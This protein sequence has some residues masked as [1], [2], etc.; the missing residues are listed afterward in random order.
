MNQEI[1][2]RTEEI[3]Q[4]E[5]QR[6]QEIERRMKE[7]QMIYDQKRHTVLER[8]RFLDMLHEHNAMSAKQQI[9]R[10]Y[11]P[12]FSSYRFDECENIK[13]SV[14]SQKWA[15]A[16]AN[17]KKAEK[18]NKEFRTLLEKEEEEALM[19]KFQNE[20]KLQKKLKKLRKSQE[21]LLSHM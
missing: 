16:R 8:K 10:K 15:T 18:K 12:Y 19:R 17:N 4:K 7:K 14:L 5:Q 1:L 21:N 6:A 20:E 3:R 9:E 2:K 11:L 13:K